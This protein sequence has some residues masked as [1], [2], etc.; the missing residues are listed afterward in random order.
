L[1]S[2]RKEE[3]AGQNRKPDAQGDLIARCFA[4]PHGRAGRNTDVTHGNTPLIGS[5]SVQAKSFAT[6]Q[7]GGVIHANSVSRF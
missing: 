1:A 3:D 6:A 5:Y 4:E 2:E 7:Y